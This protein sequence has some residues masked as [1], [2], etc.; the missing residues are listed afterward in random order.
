VFPVE[1]E[2]RWLSWNGMN[3]TIALA[4]PPL[5][6]AFYATLSDLVKVRGCVQHVHLH[7]ADLLFR[8]VRFNGMSGCRD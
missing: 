5:H 2:R 6:A 7:V 3:F 1:L 4:M 8:A